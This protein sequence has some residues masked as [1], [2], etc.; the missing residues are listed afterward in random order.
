M[1]RRKALSMTA[2]GSFAS[3]VVAGGFPA[4]VPASVFGAGAPS[5]RIAVGA[6]GTGRISRGHDMPGVWKHDRAQIVAVCDLDSRRMEDA[7]ALV[8]GHYAENT[9]RSFDGVRGYLDYKELLASPDVDAVL[10]STPDHWHALIAITA[11]SLM[12]ARMRRRAALCGRAHPPLRRI[13]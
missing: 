1:S 3:A 6:I 10:V 13:R 5:N 2:R 12:S 8:N 9:G 11:E 7:K 4:I